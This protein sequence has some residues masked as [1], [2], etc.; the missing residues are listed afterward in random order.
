MIVIQISRAAL[1]AGDFDQSK[2]V[3][4]YPDPRDPPNPLKVLAEF[5]ADDLLK[6]NQI[7]QEMGLEPLDEQNS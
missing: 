1:M 2:V 3:E 6:D 4:S 7:R 5:S